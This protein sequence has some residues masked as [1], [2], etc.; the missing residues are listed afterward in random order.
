ML[1]FLNYYLC[2]GGEVIL[3]QE[4]K[5]CYLYIYKNGTSSLEQL[6][7]TNSK[8]IHYCGADLTEFL[9]QH[10][11]N[12]LTVFLRDPIGRIISALHTQTLIYKISIDV[13]E[14]VLNSDTI[15][16]LIQDEHTIPQ[17]WYLLRAAEN[18]SNLKFK[19]KPLSE[20]KMIDGIQHL[21]PSSNFMIRN[22]NFNDRALNKLKFLYTEDIVMFENFL[23]TTTTL[24]NII[25]QIKLEKD[26]IDDI[27]QYKHQLTYL[28]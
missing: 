17:F 5:E 1:T 2:R 19:L 23:N 13:I 14:N 4:T 3:N 28:L 11:I 12:E 20:M 22:F 15:R 10:G 16:L 8:Y 25:N 7:A 26:F 27:K 9:N 24:D 6:E 21:F 18:N